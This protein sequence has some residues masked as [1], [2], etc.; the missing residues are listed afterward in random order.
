ML[1]HLHKE[2]IEEKQKRQSGTCGDIEPDA[3]VRKKP[4]KRN[5]KKMQKEKILGKAQVRNRLDSEEMDM[6]QPQD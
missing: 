4:K 3:D 5:V 1:A 6:I 2:S